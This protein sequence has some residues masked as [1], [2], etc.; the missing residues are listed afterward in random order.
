MNQTFF[1][2]RAI[3]VARFSSTPVAITITLTLGTAGG[4]M[5]DKKRGEEEVDDFYSVS[6]SN[7]CCWKAADN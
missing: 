5:D 6:V 4:R 3:F 1:L 7:V 2:R